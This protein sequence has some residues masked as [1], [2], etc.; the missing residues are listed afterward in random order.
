M[1]ALNREDALTL[2]ILEAIEK[3]SKVTQRH[4]AAR[5]DIALGLANS[6]LRR[7]ARKGLIKI[8][9]APANRYIYYLTPK[10][11]SEKSQLTARYLSSSFAFYRQAGDACIELFKQCRAKGISRIVLCGYSELAEIAL[12]RAQE[13]ALQVIGVYDPEAIAT[14][15]LG[16]PV[17]NEFC[18]IADFDALLLTTLDN[19]VWLLDHLQ[20][21]ARGEDAILVP[22]V[23][24]IR[25]VRDG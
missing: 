24:G 16:L 22:S 4:L 19:P 2:E 14:S 20:Q 3:D 7:C 18:K 9:H 11:F 17:W 25:P 15:R 10:G 13:M 21:Q 5:L 8:H 12:L 6:Y 23:L 1:N